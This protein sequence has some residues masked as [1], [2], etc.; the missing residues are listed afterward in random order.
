MDELKV[1]VEQQPGIIK[2]NFDEIKEA[3]KVQMT[4]YT[5]LEITEEN[6]KERKADLATLRKIRKAVDDERK[7]IKQEFSAPYIAFEKEVKEVLA[8]IDEPINMIDGKLKEFDEARAAEK[9]SHVKELYAENIGEYGPFLPF[10]KIFNE[11][12][13]NSTVKDKEIV[14]DLSEAKARV[15]SELNIIK[16]LNSEIED[17]LYTIYRNNDNN[18]AMAVKRNT[19]YMNDKARIEA[20]VAEQPKEEPEP[21]IEPTSTGSLNDMVEAVQTVALVISKADLQQARN[22]LDF[23]DIHY[24]VVEN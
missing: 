18:L 10:E 23:A 24:Q 22:C 17:E 1:L 9:L 11:R 21:T 15:M 20:K 8:V 13:L 2:S 19:D 4:A 16:G 3:L 5:S 14:F 12:W 7:K 6:T